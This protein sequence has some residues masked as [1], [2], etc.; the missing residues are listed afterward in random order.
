MYSISFKKSQES[1][2]V[3][4]S[5]HLTATESAIF[6]RTLAE[7]GYEVQIME[8]STLPDSSYYAASFAQLPTLEPSKQALEHASQLGHSLLQEATKSSV[9]LIMPLP[10]GYSFEL[11]KNR[12][13]RTPN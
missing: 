3:N 6:G 8:D 5:R 11:R 10:G 12:K 2:W 7:L 13:K 4:Y 1:E 9:L